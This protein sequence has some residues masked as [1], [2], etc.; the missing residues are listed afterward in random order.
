MDCWLRCR[1]E[2]AD[3]RRGEQRH[4]GAGRRGRVA[5]HA[6]RRRPARAD[7]ARRSGAARGGRPVARLAVAGLVHAQRPLAGRQRYPRTRD[8]RDA[9]P[10]VA[11]PARCASR[12]RS[13]RIRDGRTQRHGRAPAAGRS[14]ARAGVEPGRLAG[15][16]CR[17]KAVC[18]LSDF[19]SASSHAS[20][21]RRNVSPKSP[22]A[23]LALTVNAPAVESP[24]LK[25]P[26]A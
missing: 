14:G 5:A 9:A 16:S 26:I 6:G 1:G 11:G 22:F 7:A 8:R 19:S 12:R 23:K 2:R 3:L 15:R 25:A 20:S 24:R 13:S 10:V 4:A 21:S 18:C 17:S